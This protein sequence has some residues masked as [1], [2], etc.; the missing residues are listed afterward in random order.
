LRTQS[1]S[2]LSG[3]ADIK[4]KVE[5][6]EYRV[7]LIAILGSVLLSLGVFYLVDTLGNGVFVDW[8][9]RN[10]TVTYD[11]YLPGSDYKTVVTNL[12]WLGI[13]R[14]ILQFILA[15]AIICSAITASVALFYGKMKEKQTIKE[16]CRMFREYMNGDVEASKI[17]PQEYAEAAAQ[18]TE[19]KAA[20]QRHEQILKEEATRKNDLIAYL[21]HDLKT[22]LTSVIGYLSLLDEASDMPKKQK[23]K[24]TS[25]ALDKASRLEK[26]INEFFEITRY[27]L[28]QMEL[29]EET[30]DLYYMLVQMTD[31]F[32]PLLKAHGNTAELKVDEDIVVFGDSIKLARVFN[33]IL[34]NAIAYSYPDSVIEIWTEN[35]TREIHIYFRNKG[36]T[37]PA[38]KLNS[39]FEKFYRLDESR[40]TNT[41]GAGLGLAIAKEIVTLHGGKISA[42]SQREFTTFCVS[43]PT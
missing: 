31:E 23:E 5:R 17:F 12:D 11:E 10:Y 35:T 33:N 39:I 26:L 3:G 25:I 30:I 18:I 40:G 15:I 43:L 1:I 38:K 6:S 22:P 2:R 14:L 4:L 41:G 27:N 24:Y 36:K 32:Y 9:M 29:E 34:K 21:A 8:F 42:V 13:K 37:I 20:M 7:I 19:I 28:Q 16:T